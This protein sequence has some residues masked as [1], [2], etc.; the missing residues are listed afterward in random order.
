MNA[1]MTLTPEQQQAALAWLSQINQQPARAERAEFKRWLLA[2]P[3]HGEAYRQAQSLWLSTAEPAAR[4]AAE[5]AQ[6]L[7]KY[8]DAMDLPAAKW[9]PRLAG[10]AV[11]ASVVLCVAL[12][13][14]LH[15]GNWIDDFGADYVSSVGEIRSVTLADQSQLT[16]DADSAISVD[17]SHGQRQVEVRRGAVFFQVTHTGAPFTVQANGGEVRVLGTQFEVRRQADGAQ[18]TVLSGKVGVTAAPG[19]AQQVLSAGQQVAFEQGAAAAVHGVDSESQL[20]WRQ[21]WLNYYQAPLAQVVDDLSRYYP[22]R[23]VV[24]GGELGARKVSGSFPA[25]DPLAA[26]DALGAVV[27]F[28]RKT[29]LGRVTVLR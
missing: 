3:A 12:G 20:A 17:F 26:L 10:L 16:L 7:Q 18:V 8:L 9:R 29:L 27:G 19:Q 1:A 28:Q 15:P 6:A 24:L 22:G 4:L 25:D 11:A 5:E 13:A 23:I 14:G 2:D 21:G